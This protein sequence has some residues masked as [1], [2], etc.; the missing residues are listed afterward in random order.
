MMDDDTSPGDFVFH[1]STASSPKQI[2]S[3]NPSL[4][5]WTVDPEKIIAAVKRGHQA[6]GSFG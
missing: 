6:L 3:S 5:S 1:T 4:V 2:K